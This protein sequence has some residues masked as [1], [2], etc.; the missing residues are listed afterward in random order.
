MP[1]NTGIAALGLANQQ[2][3][4]AMSATERS[5]HFKKSSE[6]SKQTRKNVQ[7]GLQFP[8]LRMRRNL[9]KSTKCKVTK[10]AG[11]YLAAI[12]EYCTAEVVELAGENAIQKK[13]K[14]IMPR[15]VMMAM[16]NDEEISKLVG[17]AIIA[18]AGCNPAG[19]HP[20]LKTSNLKNS[21][22]V[23]AVQKK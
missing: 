9:K 12:L 13:K 22:W 10:E 2:R 11:I 7:A 6:K 17:K 4:K 21:E 15:H 3:I 19:I 5:A 18:S 20:S 1:G 16:K 14:R 8:T 23:S